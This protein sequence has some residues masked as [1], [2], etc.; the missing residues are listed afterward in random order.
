VNFGG[1]PSLT[2]PVGAPAL[3][4]PVELLVPNLA[5]LAIRV[6]LPNEIGPAR[7]HPAGFQTAYTSPRN[8]TAEVSPVAASTETSRFFLSGV[9]V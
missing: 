5:S 7:S 4:N 3:S 8:A 9:Y 6:Y 2:I 1:E